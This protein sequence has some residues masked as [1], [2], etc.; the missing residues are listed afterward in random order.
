MF[1]KKSIIHKISVL[2]ENVSFGQVFNGWKI[3]QQTLWKSFAA[4]I[5]EKKANNSDPSSSSLPLPYH[6]SKLW[7]S[8]IYRYLV[9]WCSFRKLSNLYP[10]GT[11]LSKA[12]EMLHWLAHKTSTSCLLALFCWISSHQRCSITSRF[13]SSHPLWSRL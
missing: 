2:K 7:R 4:T 5:Y 10:I 1:A 11:S 6:T 8:I 13:I 12:T 3:V 9:F